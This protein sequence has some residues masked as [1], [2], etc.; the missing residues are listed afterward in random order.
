MNYDRG[1]VQRGNAMAVGNGGSRRCLALP[2][3]M[4]LKPRRKPV[5]PFERFLG[6]VVAP[7]LLPHDSGFDFV[8]SRA[9]LSSGCGCI[10]S[11][12]P[13]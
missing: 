12:C 1:T 3:T 10:L 6:R 7:A 13:S 11:G 9:S 4:P 2:L 5:Q 8:S